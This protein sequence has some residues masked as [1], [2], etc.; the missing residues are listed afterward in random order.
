MDQQAVIA[1]LKKNHDNKI[2][3]TTRNH[4]E[5]GWMLFSESGESVNID[6]PFYDGSLL[7][8]G[9]RIDNF[10]VKLLSLYPS[11]VGGRQGFK[12]SIT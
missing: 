10:T 6:R 7:P 9:V 2:I 12:I 1:F 4:P 5:R 11:S 3:I 8:G